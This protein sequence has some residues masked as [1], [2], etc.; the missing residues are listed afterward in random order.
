MNLGFLEFIIYTK[1][2]RRVTIDFIDGMRHYD[3]KA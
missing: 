2:I 1:L 3:A